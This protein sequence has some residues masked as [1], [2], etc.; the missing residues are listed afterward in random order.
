MEHK[1][2]AVLCFMLLIS[3]VSANVTQGYARRALIAATG[4]TTHDPGFTT[5]DYGHSPK[6]PTSP[7]RTPNEGG[8]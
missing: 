6:P 4:F 8:S 1:L 2:V 3:T 5:Q 7:S